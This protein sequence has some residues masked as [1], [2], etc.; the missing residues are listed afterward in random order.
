M[1]TIDADMLINEINRVLPD[2]SEEKEIVLDTITNMPCLSD[3][4][5]DQRSGSSGRY[6]GL[7]MSAL[8]FIL[9]MFLG[10]AVGFLVA[11]VLSM[12]D[13]DR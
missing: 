4:T 9:G 3:A 10:G 8:A 1:K 6:G 12:E 7:Q 11:A 2:W 13:R 5:E